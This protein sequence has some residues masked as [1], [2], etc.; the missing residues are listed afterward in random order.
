M[1]VTL[2]R[3]WHEFRLDDGQ[4]VGFAAGWRVKTAKFEHEYYH[5]FSSQAAVPDGWMED[6]LC[7]MQANAKRVME[8][9]R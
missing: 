7:S 5:V 9:E 4:H 2:E 8:E 6:L 1:P 3:I